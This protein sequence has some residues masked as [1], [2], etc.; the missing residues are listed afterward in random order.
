MTAIRYSIS[1]TIERWAMTFQARRR[2]KLG[3]RIMNE[4]PTRMQRDI[5]WEPTGPA[6]H[7]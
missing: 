4:L 5:G 1:R 6:R 7:R 2:R 3:E